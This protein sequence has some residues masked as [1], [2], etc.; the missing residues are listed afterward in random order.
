MKDEI[1][2][3]DGA[4]IDTSKW[5]VDHDSLDFTSYTIT[6]I[7]EMF[8]SGAVE[9]SPNAAA[10]VLSIGLGAGYINSYLHKSY[11][12]MNITVV[13]IDR[14]MLDIALKW[15]GLELDNRHRVIIE[16]GV[17]YVKRTARAGVKFDVIH[18]DAC[19]MEENVDTNCPIDIFYTEEM[20]R[21]FAAMLKPRGVVIMNVLTLSG[22]DMAAAKKVRLLLN[23]F[24]QEQE[25]VKKAFEKA[26]KKCLGKY[27]PFS[28]PNI[29]MTCAQFQRPPGLKERYQQFRNYSTGGQS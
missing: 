8:A 28:P 3:L 26:F 27:A 6:M 21:N 5:K 24:F 11:S 4:N 17:E 14:N 22:D 25:R 29:V 19:T 1:A 12:R 10:D 9:I 18:I 15:F 13:E 7:E 16:D 20:V 23:A 2:E